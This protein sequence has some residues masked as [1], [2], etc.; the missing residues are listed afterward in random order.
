MSAEK[1]A[2]AFARELAPYVDCAVATAAATPRARAAGELAD[3]TRR[4]FKK[5]EAVNPPAAALA[6]ARALVGEKG[7]AAVAG[8]FYLAGEILTLLEGPLD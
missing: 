2:A 4:I 6:R 3:A 1:E 7:L 5:V 8:S